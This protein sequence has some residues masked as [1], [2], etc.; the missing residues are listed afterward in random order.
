MR[1]RKLKN[2]KKRIH[3]LALYSPTTYYSS[4]PYPSPLKILLTPLKSRHGELNIRVQLPLRPITQQQELRSLY[5]RTP[6]APFRAGVLQSLGLTRSPILL[7]VSALWSLA[8][9][10]R[11]LL[12]V[13]DGSCNERIWNVRRGNGKGV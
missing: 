3:T 4:S 2:M 13:W 5:D 12:G 11:R 9:R 8:S 10:S 7:G 1:K 6:H